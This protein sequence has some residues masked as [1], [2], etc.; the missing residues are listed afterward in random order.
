MFVFCFIV[1]LILGVFISPKKL[2]E[3]LWG[4][5]KPTYFSNFGLPWLVSH[6]LHD[7]NKIIKIFA[8]I[9]VDFKKYRCF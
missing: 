9:V 1:V 5:K 7:D 4:F 3:D 2:F 6:G 8:F